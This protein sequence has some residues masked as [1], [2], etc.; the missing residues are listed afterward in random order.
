MQKESLTISFGTFN[1]CLLILKEM[2]YTLSLERVANDDGSRD[3]WYSAETNQVVCSTAGS[4][5][6]LLGLVV[7]WERFG[8]KW[9]QQVPDVLEEL[10]P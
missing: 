6:E 1:P 3:T 2:G 10:E 8:V 7:L 5:P 9:N 4:V